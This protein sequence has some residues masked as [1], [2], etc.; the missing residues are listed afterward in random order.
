MLSLETAAAPRS[1][2]NSDETKWDAVKRRDGSADGKFTYSVRTTGVYCKPSCAA[3]LARRENVRFH[4]NCAAAE[5]AGFRACKRCRPNEEP[6]A[7]RFAMR[8]TALGRVA[9][10]ASEK[11][12]CAIVFGDGTEAP[13]RDLQGRFPKSRLTPGGKNFERLAEKVVRFIENHRRSADFPLDMSGTE[14]QQKVWRALREIPAGSTTNYAAIA[15]A[16][17]KPQAMRAVAQ[18]CAANRLAVAVPCH[19]VV[20]SD[21]SLSGYRWGAARKRALLAREAGA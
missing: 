16:I 14:F 2:R 18:A 20:R 12:V 21:G 6:A 19:R 1:S 13:M 8:D 3:R 10:A 17:G 11:G 5:R 4:A 9:I 7:I 15:K